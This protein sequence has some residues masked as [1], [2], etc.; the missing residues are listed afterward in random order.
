[1]RIKDLAAAAGC[2]IATVRHYER[3]GLLPPPP[4]DPGNGYRRFGAPDL[5]RLRFVLQCRQLDMPLS[6]IRPLLDWA[7]DSAAH[8]PEVHALLAEQLARVAERLRAL[9]ALQQELQ[10]LQA[11][12]DG[13]H[14][15]PCGIVDA[16][17]HGA[18]RHASMAR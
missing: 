10:G 2:D 18:G 9:Q 4:R 8:G 15:H 16:L 7:Q 17:R 13:D 1:M 12:C 3:E 6:A 11:R 5:A 14:S